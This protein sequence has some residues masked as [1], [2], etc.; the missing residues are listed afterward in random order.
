MGEFNAGGAINALAG[1]AKTAEKL[2]QSP[3]QERPAGDRSPAYT[4]STSAPAAAPRDAQRPVA[5]PGV[6]P[7]DRSAK[8]ANGE[9]AKPTKAPLERRSA[10]P[11]DPRYATSGIEQAMGALADKLHKPVHRYAKTRK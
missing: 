2:N 10:S 1:I 11:N 7:E 4:R 9:H 8:Y 3:S 6:H 5:R